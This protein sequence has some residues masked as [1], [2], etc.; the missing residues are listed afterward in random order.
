MPSRRQILAGLGAV[1][2]TAVAGCAGNQS[3]GAAAQPSDVP[4]DEPRDP[5][6]DVFGSNSEWSSFGFDASNTHWN[7]SDSAPQSGVRERWRRETG[8]LGMVPPSVTDGTLYLQDWETLRALDAESGDEQWS[9]ATNTRLRH[10]PLVRDGV[11]YV[12][13][14]R[15]LRAL[16]S[17][18]GETRWTREFEANGTPTTPAMVGH[19]QLYLGLDETLY[20]LDPETGETN[21]TR[22]VFGRITRYLTMAFGYPAVTTEAGFVYWFSSDGEGWFR[23]QLPADIRGPATSD[24][25]YL[26]TG[27]ANGRVYALDIVNSGDVAWSTNINGWSEH[28][29][30]YAR[31]SVYAYGGRSL[32]VLDARTGEKQWQFELGEVNYGTPAIADETVYVGGDELRALEPNGGVGVGSTRLGATRFATSFGGPVGPG[33][34]VDDGSIY[35]YAETGEKQYHLLALEAA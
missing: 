26:F 20:A 6:R 15:R 21:W 34:V 29:L 2:V 16:D 30:S 10:Q 12:S 18:T 9:V 8:V 3:N 25:N 7:R 24:S 22:D 35:V 23:R 4:R 27:C 28:G 14:Y 5:A 17:A 31:G 1:G 11:V 19:S 32:H 13:D 33:P